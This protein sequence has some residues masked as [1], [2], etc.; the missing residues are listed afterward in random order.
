MSAQALNELLELEVNLRGLNSGATAFGVSASEV[1]QVQTATIISQPLQDPN[2]SWREFLLV[3]KLIASAF[4]PE[5]NNNSDAGFDLK[6]FGVTTIPAW[7]S[8][9]VST[10]ITIGLPPGTYG[11]IASRSGLACNSNI[12]V[13]AG[14]IDNGYRGEIKVLLRNFSD[15]DFTVQPGDKIAQLILEVYRTTEVKEVK[16]VREIL[17]KS[18]RGVDGFGSSGR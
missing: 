7:G 1:S 13:G 5:K 18:A 16:S 17:G 8:A 10:Q 11:R 15:L 3:Q 2:N 9:V 4:I 14:V 6:A 12:E